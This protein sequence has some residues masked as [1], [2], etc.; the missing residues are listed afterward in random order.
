MDKS[1][2]N[3]PAAS[4]KSDVQLIQ[5]TIESLV[6]EHVKGYILSMVEQVW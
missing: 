1:L 5:L 4:C 2:V 3:S 6:I